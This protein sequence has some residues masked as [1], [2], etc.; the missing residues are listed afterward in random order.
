MNADVA[1]E[2]EMKTFKNKF[3]LRLSLHGNGVC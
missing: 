3:T 1:D 2:D